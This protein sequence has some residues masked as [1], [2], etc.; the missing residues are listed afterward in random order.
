MLGQGV[1]EDVLAA[2]LICFITQIPLQYGFENLSMTFCSHC[3]VGL[4]FVFPAARLRL[5]TL[6]LV[7]QRGP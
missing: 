5:E 3:N 1:T 2:V 6:V 4:T 7:E